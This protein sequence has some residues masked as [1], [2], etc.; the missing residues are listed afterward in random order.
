[1][2]PEVLPIEVSATPPLAA[3]ETYRQPEQTLAL[4]IDGG[5][6]VGL[7]TETLGTVAVEAEAAGQTE[8]SPDIPRQD[9]APDQ[10]EQTLPRPKRRAATTSRDGRLRTLRY[11]GS[12][13]DLVD[14]HK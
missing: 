6:P 2:S 12:D 8:Q 10:E 4:D 1:M 11:I 5:K 9:K 14:A 13:P 7:T 3:E